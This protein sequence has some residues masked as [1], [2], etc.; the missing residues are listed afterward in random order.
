MKA[1]ARI[2]IFISS[3]VLAVASPTFSAADFALAFALALHLALGFAA[4]G[5]VAAS[6]V[7]APARN[8]G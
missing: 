1:R 5:A 7:V 2:S 4:A 3:M 6:A 8:G